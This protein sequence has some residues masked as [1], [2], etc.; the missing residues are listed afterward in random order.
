MAKLVLIV[1][2][3]MSVFSWAVIINRWL[4]FRKAKAQGKGFLDIFWRTADLKFIFAEARSY[5]QSPLSLIFQ[6]AFMELKKWA[7]GGGI[8]S[9]T[10][11]NVLFENVTETMRK[12][13]YCEHLRLRQGLAFLATVGNTAPFVGLFGTVWGIMRAFHD[14]GLRG[15]ASLADVAPGISEALIATAFGLGAAIPAVIGYN[16]FTQLLME[17]RTEM[18]TFMTDFLNRIR[19]RYLGKITEEKESEVV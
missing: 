5:V 4:V 1:L 15:S 18:E 10:E 7:K 14:I 16:Y 12:T 11:K 9:E 8:L 17:Q 19:R 13:A 6:E 3:L 2:T